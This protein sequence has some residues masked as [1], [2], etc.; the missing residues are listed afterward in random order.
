MQEQMAYLAA[1]QEVVGKDE[2]PVVLRSSLQDA[3]L[4]AAS[5]SD[6]IFVPHGLQTINYPLALEEGGCL[7]ALHD[8]QLKAIVA[9]RAEDQH[10]FVCGDFRFEHL[11]LD[12]RNVDLGLVVKAKATV[13]M[14]HCTIVGGKQAST[15]Q[16]ICVRG[17]WLLFS[18][19]AAVAEI[20]LQIVCRCRGREVDSGTLSLR[21]PLDGRVCAPGQ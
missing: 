21:G 6:R 5:A 15:N 17:E 10:L 20:Q 11:T 14:R 8:D 7:R 3:L 13:T 12:C 1:V 4:H 9:C 2:G 19:C 18:H 16:G